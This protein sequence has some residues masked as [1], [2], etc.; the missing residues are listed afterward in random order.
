MEYEVLSPLGEIDPVPLRGLNPRVKSLEGVTIGMF[1]GFKEH[2]PLILKE[3]ELQLKQRFTTAK[4]SHYQYIKDATEIEKDEEFRGSL[5]KWLGGVDT[6]IS[7]NGDAGSCALFLAYNTAY[8]EKMG[9]PAVMLVNRFFANVARSGAAYRNVPYLRFVLNDIPDLS[10]LYSFES[11]TER[12]IRPEVEKI[13]D[14]IIDALIKPL[15]QEE[16]SPK[17]KGEP[18]G[19]VF[20]GTLQQVNT[21]FYKRGWTYGLPIVP[22][23]EDAVNEMIR[24]TDLPSDYVV[25]KIPP[26]MGKATVRKI[27]INAVM[28]GCLPTY[29]PVLIAAVEALTDPKVFCGFGRAL[30][31]WTCSVASWAPLIIVNGPIRHDLHINSSIACLSPYYKANAAIGHALGLIIMNIGGVR[32]GIEDMAMFGHEGRF[33]IC[34]AE[35]EEESPWEPLHVTLG[36]KKEDSAVTVFWPNTRQMIPGGK[37]TGEILRNVCENVDVFGFDPGCAFI[38]NPTAAKILADAGLTKKDVISYIVEY[39]RRPASE[40]NVRWLKGNNHL[41][42]LKSLPLPADP[43]R[44]T[45]KFWTAEHLIIAVASAAHY[46]PHILAYGGGGDHGGPSCQKIETPANWDRLVEEYKDIVPTYSPF[47]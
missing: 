2:W 12:I 28:A 11:I 1:A 33:G 34:I 38:M 15:T 20:K 21:F 40:V 46:A 6:V 30:E 45:R 22:P 35:N 42:Q 37:T 47:S 16:I 25:A 43:T 13:L 14:N 18:L 27:A 17:A 8:I 7:A 36:L 5:D 23:T 19:V 10:M 26:R 4:F 32:P 44:P 39:A 24:A 29:M 3:V 31:G 9:K 41:W